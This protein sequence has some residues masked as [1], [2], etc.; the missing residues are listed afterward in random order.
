WSFEPEKRWR[1]YLAAL[2]WGVGLTAHQT[3]VLLTV[4]FPTFIWFTDRKFGRNVLMPILIVSAFGLLHEF[5]GTW[6]MIGVL[7]RARNQTLAT[8]NPNVPSPWNTYTFPLLT[9]LGLAVG[10][11]YWVYRMLR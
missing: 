6:E 9:Y 4:A 7:E 1:L 5:K 3:L 2:I 8:G 10:T 11:G